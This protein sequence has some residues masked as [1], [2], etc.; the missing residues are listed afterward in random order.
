MPFL[1]FLYFCCTNFVPFLSIYPFCCNKYTGLVI[2]DSIEKWKNMVI[3]RRFLVF[4]SNL[5][6]FLEKK[7]DKCD[8]PIKPLI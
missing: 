4:L 6:H 5:S 8:L 2:F 1:Y 3:I 7:C